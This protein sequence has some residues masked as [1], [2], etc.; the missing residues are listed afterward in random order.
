M[1][2]K[3]ERENKR[4]RKMRAMVGKHFDAKKDYLS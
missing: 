2:E 3:G 1:R 4:Q